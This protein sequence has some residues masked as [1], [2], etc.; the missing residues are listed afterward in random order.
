ME[1]TEECYVMFGRRSLFGVNY[2][3]KF[4]RQLGRP[5]SGHSLSKLGL[6]ML[7]IYPCAEHSTK[8]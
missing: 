5:L 4:S 8:A 1:E 2:I 7:I 3:Q 6:F